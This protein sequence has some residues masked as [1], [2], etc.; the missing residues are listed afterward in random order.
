MRTRRMRVVK[1]RGSGF[2]GNEYPYLFTPRGVVVMPISMASLS[3]QTTAALVSTGI[4]DLDT[5]MHG[6]YLEGS[7]I[8]VAGP[9]GSGKTTL[10][11][12]FA[13]EACRRGERVLYVSYE[14]SENSIS[15]GMLSV[16]IDLRP[17]LGN[18]GLVELT[19]IPE[20]AGAEQH[21]LRI[22]DTMDEFQPHHLVLDAVSACERM[23]GAGSAFDFLVR[24][25]T[26]CKERGVTSLMTNQTGS[27]EVPLRISGIGISSLVDALIGLDYR[28]DGERLH[29][30][31]IAVKARAIKHSMAY[32]EMRITDHGIALDLSN[33]RP[34]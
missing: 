26:T 3:Q 23:G 5:V 16:G 24:L 9:S 30:R 28:D 25:I 1:Y 17:A 33:L 8:L 13:K 4:E 31:L 10:A 29:R 34:E 7:S 2:L 21:L 27:G 14:E 6:G 22:R 12:S 11:C 15:R 18:G 19:T 32:H 20:S